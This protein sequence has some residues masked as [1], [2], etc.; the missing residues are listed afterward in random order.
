MKGLTFLQR[1][2]K[3]VPHGRTRNRIET[4]RGRSE[5]FSDYSKQTPDGRVFAGPLDD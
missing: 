2:L 5:R 4:R 3:P 1:G